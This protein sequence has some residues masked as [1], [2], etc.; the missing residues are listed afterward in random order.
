MVWIL[1][2]ACVLSWVFRPGWRPSRNRMISILSTSI[3]IFLSALVVFISQ[4]VYNAAG[5]QGVSSVANTFH[6]IS[7]AMIGGAVLVSAVYSILNKTEIA[8]GMGFG[9]C[10]VVVI[11]SLEWIWLDG[12]AGA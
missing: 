2:A 10:I 1:I 11:S 3:P 8:K 9:I 6:I 12:L 7:L 5:N 4:I